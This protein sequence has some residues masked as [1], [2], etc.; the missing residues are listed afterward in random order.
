M[1]YARTKGSLDIVQYAKKMRVGRMNM[2]Q[3]FVSIN[4]LLSNNQNSLR[5]PFSCVLGWCNG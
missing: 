5:F 1:K 2:I 3:T 4:S